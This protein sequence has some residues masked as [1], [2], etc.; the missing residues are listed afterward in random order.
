MLNN[1][2]C[3]IDF[4]FS[5]HSIKFDKRNSVN[6]PFWNVYVLCGECWK[7]S[8]IKCISRET[9]NIAYLFGRLQYICVHRSCPYSF[10]NTKPI[11]I[12]SLLIQTV[13][14]ILLRFI[15]FSYS[16]YLFIWF[17]FLHSG[18]KLHE[19]WDWTWCF[20]CASLKM[21]TA[22]FFSLSVAVCSIFNK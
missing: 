14:L 19:A 1:F 4:A 18:L 22:F 20:V 9:R 17:V 11:K 13:F 6:T 10:W 15:I 7:I 12:F 3:L 5:F 8:W 21:C 2:L 16:L